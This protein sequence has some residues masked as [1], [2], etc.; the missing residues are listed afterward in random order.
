MPVSP[1]I[2]TDV[3]TDTEMTAEEA[4]KMREFQLVVTPIKIVSDVIGI[5]GVSSAF[6]DNHGTQLLSKDFKF[7]LSNEVGE[8][9]DDDFEK[10]GPNNI[11]IAA[12]TYNT[13]YGTSED[14]ALE[15]SKLY[16]PISAFGEPSFGTIGTEGE[17]GA[18]DINVEYVQEERSGLNDKY[19]GFPS[20]T[21]AASLITD[22]FESLA[23]DAYQTLISREQ[24]PN[25]IQQERLTVDVLSDFEN[26]GSAGVSV[27]TAKSTA[28]RP[29][30]DSESR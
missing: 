17:N 30:P 3:A 25:V 16:M 11:G 14:E 5:D 21:T 7:H 28:Y 2:D 18:V 26:E 13:G 19:G 6:V 24:I 22:A 1:T 27:A 20:G 15:T 8:F 29:A 10:I 23:A 9:D 4:A 12:Q